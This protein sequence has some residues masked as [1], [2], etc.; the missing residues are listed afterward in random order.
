MNQIARIWNSLSY[1]QRI[2]LVVAPILVCAAAFAFVRWRH[3]SDFRVLYT[4][5]APEDASAVTQ[6]IR[7]AAI[8]YRLDETGSTVLVPSARIAEARLALAGAGLPRTGRIGFELFDR[9]NL[10]AS[11][12]TEQVN[13]RR[14]LEGELERTVATL[15]EIEQARIHISFAKESV[16]L[17]SR[18]PAK[19]TVVLRLRR[20]SR[21]QSPSVAAI[22]NLVA[23][24][25]DGLAPESVA[26]IDSN[27]RLLN[28][29]RFGDDTDARMAEA[30][31]DYRH[32]VESDLLAKVNSALEP[33]LGSGRFRAGITVDCDFTTSEQSDEVYEASKS[34]LLQSQSS[35]EATSSGVAGGTPG[36]ASNL[37]RPPATAIAGSSG[38]TRRTENVSYQPGRTVRKTVVPKG[39]VKRISTAVLV[40]QTVR[41][42]GAGA[43]ARRTV[44]PPSPEVLKGIRDVIAGITGYS[45][46]RGDLITVETL[47]FENTL[48]SEPPGTAQ[49]AP[50]ASQISD[51]KR[52]ILIY[53]GC[54]ILLLVLAMTFL[55]IRRSS[56][57]R[58]VSV[59][60]GAATAIPAQPRS[61]PGE[62]ADAKSQQQ[63]GAN[64]TDQAQSELDALNRI[65]L[66]VNTRK[67]EVLVRHIRDAVEKDP[68]TA[69][70]VLRT[71]VAD[72]DTRRTS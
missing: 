58:H 29:P 18:Q 32:Q 62:V 34:A 70:N 16:F 57:R 46:A 55:L 72:I 22:A 49:P 19:A 14:A 66:P 1:A 67:T 40:D 11:D 50:N 30:D 71:W 15:S 52:P 13:Y 51:L 42:E 35:E 69:A 68:V 41:W 44:I 27:G 3:E 21:L 25:V 9:A 60:D 24:A 43:K 33:L 4:S 2:S 36:T 23:S 48:S 65:K 7:E 56:G 31:L 10:G 54:A 59:E 20:A 45:E 64:P 39:S 28:R 47:P 63:I 26:I 17:D 8:E 12:F 53:G 5:L 37:P 38:V 61:A 6:K